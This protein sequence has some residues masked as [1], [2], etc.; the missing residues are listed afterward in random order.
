MEPLKNMADL[1]LWAPKLI[2]D[3]I[4]DPIGTVENRPLDLVMLAAGG[5]L[6]KGIKKA[7]EVVAP[8]QPIP[9]VAGVIP[10][11][12]MPPVTP[13]LKTAR[14]FMKTE[15]GARTLISD[16]ERQLQ[17]YEKKEALTKGKPAAPPKLRKP[18]PGE[19]KGLGIEFVDDAGRPISRAE[20][21][22]GRQTMVE[23]SVE[24]PGKMKAV[25]SPL[26]PIDDHVAIVQNA[27]KEAFPI[28]RGQ[29]TLYHAEMQKRTAGVVEAGKIPGEVGFYAKL[30]ELKG[31]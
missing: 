14:G 28:R 19:V 25:I 27:I 30:G 13:S 1:A 4:K 21:F 9:D 31:P 18:G 15:K 20:A 23:P 7:R 24:E 8:K 12:Q 22:R 29:E 17:E 16:L 10:K 11:E 3:V 26:P 2:A 5:A 6:H